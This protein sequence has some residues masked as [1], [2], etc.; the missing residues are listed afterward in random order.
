MLVALPLHQFGV[1]QLV[2]LTLVKAV[3]NEDGVQVFADAVVL[4]GLWG[5]EFIAFLKLL[6]EVLQDL[7]VLLREVS[8]LLTNLF[9]LQLIG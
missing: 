5:L 8:F 6:N 7:R 9:L 4:L 1:E 2:V 3:G